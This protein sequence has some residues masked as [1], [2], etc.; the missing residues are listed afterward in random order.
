MLICVE[1]IKC[2]V[3]VQPFIIDYPTH[4]YRPTINKSMLRLLTFSC[5]SFVMLSYPTLFFRCTMLVP[6]LLLTRYKLWVM[7]SRVYFEV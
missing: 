4:F 3:N 1:Y 5:P 6:L 2:N 7:N